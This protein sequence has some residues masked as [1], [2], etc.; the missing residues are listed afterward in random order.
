MNPVLRKTLSVFSGLIAAFLCGLLLWPL[1]QFM[2]DKFIDIYFV[3]PK[4][5]DAWLN[6]LIV[7]LTAMI[8][9]LL[10]SITG[11]IVCTLIALI[12]EWMFVVISII[13]VVLV[14]TIISKGEI[15][16]KPE[17]E[18]VVLMLMIPMGFG[19]GFLIGRKIKK[20]RQ[21]KKIPEIE[22]ENA[23]SDTNK[24]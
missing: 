12:K 3:S 14:L 19:I 9:L 10:C 2:F 17:I 18:S 1:V 20:R 22:F 8:W 6:N 24:Q 13:I 11:G 7:L 16:Y 21:R 23:S 5:K 15:F 4:Q